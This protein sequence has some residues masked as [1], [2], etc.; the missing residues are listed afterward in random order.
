[1]KSDSF[2]HGR[3]WKGTTDFKLQSLTKTESN[4]VQTTLDRFDC[5]MQWPQ[6]TNPERHQIIRYRWFHQRD[7]TRI[8]GR[9]WRESWW[10]WRRINTLN[11]ARR[12]S[13]TTTHKKCPICI[14][15]TIWTGTRKDGGEQYDWET[16]RTQLMAQQLCNRKKTQRKAPDMFRPQTIN[17]GTDNNY[18]CQVPSL[19]SIMHMFVLI[20]K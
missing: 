2:C 15:K 10:I 7:F 4:T 14:G 18:H 3:K 13:Y 12:S 8:P 6:R 9:F 5:R 16:G 1:M 20:K 19:E 17:Q 11:R